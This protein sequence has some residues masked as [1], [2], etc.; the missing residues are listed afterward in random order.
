MDRTEPWR[1][2]QLHE[3]IRRSLTLRVTYPELGRS[4]PGKKRIRMKYRTSESWF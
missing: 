1:R 3:A 4:N 2:T